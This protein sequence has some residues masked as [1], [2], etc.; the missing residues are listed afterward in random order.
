MATTALLGL[1]FTLSPALLTALRLA[2]LVSSTASLTHAY[3]ES[4]T[5]ASFL[6]PAPIDSGLSRLLLGPDAPASSKGD[7]K[8][9]DHKAEKELE[10]AMDFAAPNW[11]VKFFNT[12]IWSVIGFNSVTLLS[13]SLNLVFGESLQESRVFYGLGLAAAAAH[14]AFV[15]AVGASVRG[16]FE[17]CA[18][19]ESGEEVIQNGKA[20][21]LVR[22][23]NGWHNIR[24]GSV[25][26]VAW[27][28]FAWGVVQALTV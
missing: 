23:W 19:R 11:F 20:V 10:G 28:C 16:L 17:M 8:A 24:M 4:V 21:E 13:A 15:P 1:T 12:A 5:T 27:G 26:V 6:G 14:Y 25:D 3:M 7:G 22:E 9:G 18:A 2:P